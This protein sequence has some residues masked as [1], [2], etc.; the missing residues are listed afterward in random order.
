MFSIGVQLSAP[1]W[2]AGRSLAGLRS[3]DLWGLCNWQPGLVLRQDLF[4]TIQE[5]ISRFGEVHQLC[6]VIHAV[7]SEAIVERR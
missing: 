2:V 5:A 6:G 7:L 4:Q 3:C 1:R